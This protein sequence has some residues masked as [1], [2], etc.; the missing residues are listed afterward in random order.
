MYIYIYIP[1]ASR[2]KKNTTFFNSAFCV[3]RLG[4]RLRFGYVLCFGCVLVAFL[5]CVLHAFI[6]FCCVLNIIWY[7]FGR[8]LLLRFG[9]VL[10]CNAMF[11]YNLCTFCCYVSVAFCKTLRFACL[12]NTA[13]C[14]L[15]VFWTQHFATLS[16][17]IYIYIYIYIYM[18]I[19]LWLL[20]CLHF[21]RMFVLVCFVLD[22]CCFCAWFVWLFLFVFV[23][24]L[25]F[26]LCLCLVVYVFLFD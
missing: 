9:S 22:F 15:F 4:L 6:Y 17:Y 13:F 12:Q 25:L 8:V 16:V 18:F 5:A 26:M 10:L 21:V 11:S 24:V 19:C 3:L 20:I 14:N 23:C 2:N 7:H 1:S